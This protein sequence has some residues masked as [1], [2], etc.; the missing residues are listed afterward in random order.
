MDGAVA[1]GVLGA[2]G[3]YARGGSVGGGE[4]VNAGQP[5]EGPA[6]TLADRAVDALRRYVSVLAI[7]ALLLWLLPRVVRGAA[8]AARGGR[9]SASGSGSSGS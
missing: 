6:P 2:T 3:S 1:G 8:G 7:G 9:W 5:E 4:R